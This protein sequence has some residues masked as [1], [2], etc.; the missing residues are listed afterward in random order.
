MSL[1][2]GLTQVSR[3]QGQCILA[4]C[5]SLAYVKSQMPADLE[6]LSALKALVGQMMSQDVPETPR[7]KLAALPAPA[8]FCIIFNDQIPLCSFVFVCGFVFPLLLLPLSLEPGSG[9]S[10]P[11]LC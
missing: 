2:S 7:G 5:F 9:A 8:L 10:F 3:R 1:R 6:S 4:V 11:G